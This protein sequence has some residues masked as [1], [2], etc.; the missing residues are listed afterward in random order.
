MRVG[1][2]YARPGGPLVVSLEAET[3]GEVHQFGRWHQAIESG[4]GAVRSLVIETDEEAGGLRW[5]RSVIHIEIARTPAG[6]QTHPPGTTVH[7]NPDGTVTIT[8]GPNGEPT[9]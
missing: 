6:P 3:F 7:L 2:G 8:P 9:P 1:I 5:A 4:G